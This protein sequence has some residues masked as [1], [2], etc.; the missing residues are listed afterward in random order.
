[1]HTLFG[2]IIVCANVCLRKYRCDALSLS[3]LCF[4]VNYVVKKGFFQGISDSRIF[5]I[6]T[7]AHLSIFVWKNVN[8]IFTF[9]HVYYLT[10]PALLTTARLLLICKQN[11]MYVCIAIKQWSMWQISVKLPSSLIYIHIY[12]SVYA[13]ACQLYLLLYKFLGIHT[14]YMPKY[15][16]YFFHSFFF[17]ANDWFVCS[18]KRT[19]TKWP[20]ICLYAR[21]RLTNQLYLNA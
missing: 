8:Y 4:T 15:F 5:H 12:V 2:Y 17:F 14:A 11:C 10:S 6:H 16:I 9:P 20:I 13:Y 19:N 7:Y 21:V 3:L 18:L 1:M